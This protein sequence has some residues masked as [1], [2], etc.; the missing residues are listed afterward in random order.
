MKIGFVLIVLCDFIVRQPVAQ[1]GSFVFAF[2]KINADLSVDQLIQKGID[3][4]LARLPLIELLQAL[5]IV[6]AF[7]RQIMIG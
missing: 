6:M 4:A 7:E 3:I 5:R 1:L 2:T